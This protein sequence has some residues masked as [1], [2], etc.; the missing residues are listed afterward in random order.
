[1]PHQVSVSLSI[2]DKW[3]ARIAQH[4]GTAARRWLAAVICLGTLGCGYAVGPAYQGD[5]HTV[6]VPVFTSESFRRD[7]EFQ[8]TEAVQK[9]IQQ[10]TPFR[11]AKGPN[12]DTRLTGR[13]VE[14]RK[15]VL[16]ETGFDDPREL[17][18]LFAVE[19]TWED[20]RT[21][22][23]LSQQQF[24]IPGEAVTLASTGDFAPEVG[25]SLATGAQRAIDD[26]S[27]QIVEMM[28][29]PW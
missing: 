8:L 20:L 24:A 21:G 29:V 15:N 26:L 14:I 28:E 2:D 19:V 1:M 22:Q 13:I 6:A 12:A 18:L 27:R 23:L 10:Q 16:G 25:Q 11:I 17:Q 7:F 9:E 3:T 4:L 5:I